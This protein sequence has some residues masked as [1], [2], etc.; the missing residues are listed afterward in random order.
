MKTL[1]FD[2]DG[3]LLPLKFEQFFQ[4]YLQSISVYCSAVVDPPLF[5]R[6]LLKCTHIMLKNDGSLTNE[7][8]F[9]KNFLP[10]L[11]LQAGDIYPVLE[12][13]YTRE[14]GRLRRFALP[15]TLAPRIVEHVVETGWQIVLA[16]NPL[17]PRL[18]IE[19]RMRW[20]G[21]DRFPWKYITSYETSRACKPSLLYYREIMDKLDLD[22]QECWMVG[23]D[24]TEDMAAGRL[25]IK[26]YLVTDYCCGKGEDCPPPD[27]QG[28]LEDFFELIKGSQSVQLREA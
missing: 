1:L 15:S 5:V 20:A 25:G 6:E 10:A 17:F 16:T 3:T 18:A 9:M 26:T 11:G 19:E 4:E 12:S 2:L 13:Y 8:I 14:F 7:E 24:L 22:P 21:I 23:N 28:T 27:W